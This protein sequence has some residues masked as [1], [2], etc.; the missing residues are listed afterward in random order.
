MTKVFL[1][2]LN[3]SLSSS[4]MIA[5]VL[6][7]RK[8]TKR[9][10]NRILCVLWGLVFLRL[11][12]PFTISDIAS[13]SGPLPNALTLIE[14]PAD[15]TPIATDAPQLNSETGK[16]MV[17]A[18]KESVEQSIL[19]TSIRVACFVWLAGVAV[20]LCYFC[21]T[22]RHLGQAIASGVEAQGVVRCAAIS[23]PF[24]FGIVH[25]R[26]YVPVDIDEDCLNNVIAH[27]R[28]HVR[29]RDHLRK[30]LYTLVLSVYWFHPL[31]WIAFFLSARDIEMACDDVVIKN[32]N[33]EE[34]NHYV[35]SILSFGTEWPRV[36]RQYVGF[37]DSSLKERLENIAMNQCSSR[38]FKAT[39]VTVGIA[40]FSATLIFGAKAMSASE[41]TMNDTDVTILGVE[42]AD[43]EWNADQY[44]LGIFVWEIAPDNYRCMLVR[45]DVAW[46]DA[47]NQ[48]MVAAIKNQGK[49]IAQ[50]REFLAAE[51]TPKERILVKYFPSGSAIYS[52]IGHTYTS[53]EDENAFLTY[54]R[55]L[56]LS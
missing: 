33:A 14:Q 27:E 54:L 8:I 44:D 46:E 38:L 43:F 19:R 49:T 12:C 47:K 9:R 45:C 31:V 11:L 25:P 56:L 10:C 28:T 42:E 48:V 1:V 40:V 2:L 16:V 53:R 4:I 26:I 23:V 5:V 21:I 3:I 22:A 51:T 18:E 7:I 20:M 39:I 36:R 37:S 13:V 35:I 6:L 15:N 55:G 17:S 52:H 29:H 34:R 50:A 24:V 30:I 41:E 32:M